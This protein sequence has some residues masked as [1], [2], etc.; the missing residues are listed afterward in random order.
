VLDSSD[1]V[2]GIDPNEDLLESADED[3]VGHEIELPPPPPLPGRGGVEMIVNEASQAALATL[4]TRKQEKKE[5]RDANANRVRELVQMTGL[6]HA[7]VNGQLNRDAGVDKITEA[8]VVQLERRL[9]VADSWI[10]R[11]VG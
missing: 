9:R 11:L 6:G 1:L 7:Q 4:K 10:R 2:D 3:L 5:L 8:T